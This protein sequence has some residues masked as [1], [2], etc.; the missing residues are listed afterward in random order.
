MDSYDSSSYILLSNIYAQFGLWDYVRKVQMM[1][2]ER[3]L[4]KVPGSSWI[5]V[6]GTVHEFFVGSASNQKEREVCSTISGWSELRS[7][8]LCSKH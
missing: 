5:E 8:L 7:E 3:E 6:E 4:N 1:M 2:K